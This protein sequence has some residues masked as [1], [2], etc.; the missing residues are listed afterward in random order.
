M[1]TIIRPV[2]LFKSYQDE[3]RVIIKKHRDFRLQ[4]ESEPGSQQASA[5]P[6][7]SPRL[8]EARTGS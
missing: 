2:Q 4:R 8:I 1:T 6:N 5:Y 3:G 7:E